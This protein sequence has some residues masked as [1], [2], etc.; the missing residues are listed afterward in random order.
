MPTTE[1]CAKDIQGYINRGNNGNEYDNKEVVRKLLKARLEKA[2][3]MGY[4]NYASFAL[5]ERMAKTPD[6]VYKLLDQIWTPTLSKAKEELADINAEI[7]KDGKPSQ[8]KVGTGVI[9]QTG[10]RKPNS[11]WMKIRYVL[12]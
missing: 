6:A 4:E 7:K 2:K 5:E 1:T 10:P 12:I 3:L 9:M 11:T 8:P